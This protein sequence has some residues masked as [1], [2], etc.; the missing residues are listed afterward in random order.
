MHTVDQSTLQELRE[1]LTD[2]RNA[3]DDGRV[4]AHRYAEILRGAVDEYC[5]EFDKRAEALLKRLDEAA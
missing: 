5:V 1:L 3:S 4:L 2:L